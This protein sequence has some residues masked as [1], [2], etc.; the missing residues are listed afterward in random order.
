[1]IFSLLSLVYYALVGLIMYILYHIKTTKS[2]RFCEFF[3]VFIWFYMFIY[4]VFVLFLMK[5]HKKGSATKNLECNR[6]RDF[7]FSYLYSLKKYFVFIF[8]NFIIVVVSIYTALSAVLSPHISDWK[9]LA[10]FHH[11]HLA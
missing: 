7:C 11:H 1:M 10:V 5:R 6:I 8:F 2:T 4:V 9:H 3:V